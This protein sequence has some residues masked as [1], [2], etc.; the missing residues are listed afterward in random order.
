MYNL[1]APMRHRINQ[2]A[3]ERGVPPYRILD[4]AIRMIE[5]G[6]DDIYRLYEIR[7]TV[8]AEREAA[9]ATGFRRLFHK[10]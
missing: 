9:R 7:Q 2:I 8:R 5:N 10:V 3:D 6:D 1:T 4:T